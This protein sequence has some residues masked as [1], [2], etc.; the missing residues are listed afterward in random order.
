[1]E[2]LL[3]EYRADID[4]FLPNEEYRSAACIGFVCEKRF[5]SKSNLRLRL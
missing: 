5:E 2:Y 3:G 1:M 4:F